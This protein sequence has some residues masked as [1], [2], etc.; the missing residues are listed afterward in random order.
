MPWLVE[1]VKEAEGEHL[2]AYLDPIGIP[3]IG[4]G[5]TRIHGRSV[6][7]GDTITGGEST[8]FLLAELND[9]LDYVV[10]Y[11]EE[12]GYNW[13]NNQ[14]AALTSFV[15]NLGKG[16]LKMLTKNAT[17]DDETI[18]RKMLL[19]VNA[20]GRKLPGLVTRRKREAEHFNS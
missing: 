14:I 18:A 19:Y 8:R 13:N 4:V 20:G 17:R 9:F 3:T 1:F 2:S 15:F 11:S 5:L 6:R 12:H 16:R 7:L 10:D